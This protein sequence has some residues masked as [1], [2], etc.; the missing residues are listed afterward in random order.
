VERS[1]GKEPGRGGGDFL[2]FFF[3]RPLHGSRLPGKRGRLYSE[4]DQN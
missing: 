2:A 4:A 1:S 3:I